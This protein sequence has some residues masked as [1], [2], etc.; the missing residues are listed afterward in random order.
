MTL[1]PL[2]SWVIT[3]LLSLTPLPVS[4]YT[5][6]VSDITGLGCRWPVR[7]QVTANETEGGGAELTGQ[8]GGRVLQV[9]PQANLAAKTFLLRAELHPPK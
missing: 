9:P 4:P 7:P 5:F 8:M 3:P 6:E 1:P 2:S